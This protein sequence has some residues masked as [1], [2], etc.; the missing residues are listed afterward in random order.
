MKK[1]A[2][3]LIVLAVTALIYFRGLT[4]DHAWPDDFAMYIMHAENMAEDRPYADT[5]YVQNP[6]N[7]YVGPRAYPPG[8]PLLLAPVYKIFGLN[9]KA[10]KAENVVFFLLALYAVYMLVLPRIG[11]K[12]ALFVVLL[13]AANPWS[14]AFR[15]YIYSDWA[16]MLFLLGGF[17]FWRGYRENFLMRDAALSSLFFFFAVLT[18]TVCIIAPAAVVL[19]CLRGQ[20]LRK[21]ALSVAGISLAA[22]LVVRL[23]A[24]GGNTPSYYLSNMRLGQLIGS[25]P[26]YV[27]LHDVVFGF[28]F[29]F[30]QF[31]SPDSNVFAVIVCC[32]V[33]IFA[34]AGFIA[35]VRR[36]G[37]GEAEIFLPL[38]FLSFLVAYDWPRNF[39]PA[40]PF[41]L[42]YAVLGLTAFAGRY[43][44]RAKLII[45]LGAVLPFLVYAGH[46]RSPQPTQAS[47]MEK[48]VAE[49]FSFVRALPDSSVVMFRKPRVMCLL[50][51]RKS[52]SF[53]LGADETVLQ[54][55][56]ADLSV[57]YV[58]AGQFMRDR[59]EVLPVVLTNPPWLRTVFVNRDFIV[60]EVTARTRG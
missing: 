38:Y 3:L 51:G 22:L 52:V 47:V 35:C 31:I 20:R 33:F 26:W 50:T 18:R 37:W 39:F 23:A 54:K 16:A 36:D 1:T 45:A 57:K 25:G 8:Y 32:A 56:I 34:A 55:N 17:L 21:A 15:Q 58:V 19:S 2:Y 30:S 4:N 7:D 60:Y 27:S 9:L 40:A 29:P 49:M 11:E 46:Y 10:F 59:R 13:L 41:Y 28:M 44:K 53:P 43:A 14:F 5:P 12:G 6:L 24:S 42:S 48:N